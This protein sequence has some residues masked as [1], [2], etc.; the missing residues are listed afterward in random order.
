MAK[1]FPLK[2][3]QILNFVKIL[4]PDEELLKNTL[5]SLPSVATDNVT[6]LHMKFLND[7]GLPTSP[8]NNNDDKS[9][10]AAT[11][12]NERGDPITNGNDHWIDSLAASAL[13]SSD[14]RVVRMGRDGFGVKCDGGEACWRPMVTT[15][16]P[17]LL[18]HFGYVI[19][20][21]SV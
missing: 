21:R 19:E 12:T 3:F 16:W 4:L 6:P 18:R 9:K 17:R 10:P 7:R 15:H 11:A 1:I 8:N 2:I 5:R 20:S 14:V 13:N